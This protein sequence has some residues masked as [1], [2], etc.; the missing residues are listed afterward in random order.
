[1]RADIDSALNKSESKSITEENI[2]KCV[3]CGL[4]LGVCPL[5]LSEREEGFSPRGKIHT[6]DC[7]KER[8]VIKKV[9]NNCL[10]CLSC[11]SVCP[12]GVNIPDAI[13]IFRRDKS[14]AGQIYFLLRTVQ[15]KD[16]RR[17]RLICTL[18]EIDNRAGGFL[19]LMGMSR[20][21]PEAG[22]EKIVYNNFLDEKS[23]GIFT[24]CISSVFYPQI[25]NHICKFYRSKG[26]SVYIPDSQVCCGLMNSSAGD[27]PKALSLA[28]RNTEL[29]SSEKIEKIIT[30]CASCAYMLR[31]YGKLVSGGEIISRKI[32]PPDEMISDFIQTASFGDLDALHIPCHI[33]NAEEK[34]FYNRLKNLKKVKIIDACCGYGGVFNLYEY[35]KSVKIG[36]KILKEIKGRKS[37]YTLCSGCYLHLYD[38]IRKNRID[39]EVKSLFELI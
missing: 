11:R 27:E 3:R 14:I 28:L 22:K 19:K 35:E 38:V 37:V 5:Y 9:L 10:L 26:Y 21:I 16:F 2:A 30:P 7:S 6:I 18:M 24:G 31:Q 25:I 34:L 20:K 33:R 15:G 4:C 39:T 13:K 12:N 17:F 1:M 29:F 36:E 32:Y 8:A 23:I